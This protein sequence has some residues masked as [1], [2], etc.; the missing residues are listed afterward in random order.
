MSNEAERAL[1]DLVAREQ[2]GVR[3]VVFAGISVLLLLVAT[4]VA[5]AIVFYTSAESLRE[6]SRRLSKNAFDTRRTLDQQVNRVAGLEAYTRTTY[7][8]IRSLLDTDTQGID[9]GAALPVAATYLQRGAITLSEERVLDHCS[10]GQAASELLPERRA[11]L[12]GAASLRAWERSRDSVPREG[13][14]PPPELARAR[15]RFEESRSDPSLLHLSNN[16]LAWVEFI[17]AGS[18]RHNFAEAQCASVIVLSRLSTADAASGD[19]ALQP[20]YWIGQCARKTARSLEALEAYGQALVKIRDIEAENPARGDGTDAE[21]LIKMNAFH[22]LGTVLISTRDDPEDARLT[23]ARQLADTVC[24]PGE[25]VAGG[26]EPLALAQAC[27]DEA[28]ALR[29]KLRQ[30]RNQVSGSKENLTFIHLRAGETGKAF[31]VTREIETTGLFPWNELMR[32]LTAEKL[33]AEI[34]AA[35]PDETRE[36]RNE[37][38]RFLKE[39]GN[40]AKVARRNVSHYAINQ[41]NLCEIE[42]LLT[43]EDYQRAL[44]IIYEEH[45]P[46]SK[47]L[48]LAEV[49]CKRGGTN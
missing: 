8:E 32:V 28:I 29:Q 15:S 37:T 6:E 27:L 2:R 12:S 41:F 19:P 40:T 34:K 45:R 20:L 10:S 48:T 46:N 38:G 9:C 25:A 44:E 43:P 14:G 3:G 39:L 35:R 26:R 11:L 42:V 7:D 4:S 30:T 18:E 13:D 36:Q 5:M 1:L 17:M 47:D 33:H 23:A 49:G 31:E 21:L 24:R 22:G 16:G